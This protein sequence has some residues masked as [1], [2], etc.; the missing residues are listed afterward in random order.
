MRKSRTDLL[1]TNMAIEAG[2]VRDEV[3][4]E[5]SALARQ[6]RV[7]AKGHQ[8]K[9]KGGAINPDAILAATDRIEQLVEKVQSL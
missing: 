7:M 9:A 1:Y 4:K 3:L 5:I 6:I 2:Y 8:P